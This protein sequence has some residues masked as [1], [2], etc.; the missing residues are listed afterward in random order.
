MEVIAMITAGLEKLGYD[1]FL[2]LEF[3]SVTFD[4]DTKESDY[5][6]VVAVTPTNLNIDY[7]EMRRKS[8]FKDLPKLLSSPTTLVFSVW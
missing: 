4:A 8:F 7:N 1:K 5:D 6:I 2:F 3:G